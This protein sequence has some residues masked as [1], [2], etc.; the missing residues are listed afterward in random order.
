MRRLM[1]M[2]GVVLLAAFTLVGVG[3]VSVSA[4]GEE[5]VT[6]TTGKTKSK[7]TNVQKLKMGSSTIECTTAT[8]T[9]EVKST[10][11]TTH[12]EVVTYGGCSG[13]G[14]SLN[15]SPAHFEVYANGSEKLESRV[16]VSSES[17]IC[18]VYIEPQTMTGISYTN[19]SGKVTA[20][21]SVTGIHY[22][23]T[24]EECGGAEG[25]NGSY[26]GSVQ[27]ELEGGTVEWKS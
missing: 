8:G 18:K 14:V 1:M 22:K 24:G 27:A 5:F 25:T 11:M 10:T 19:S 15:V 21:T 13:L 26:S 23:P 12:K 20:T 7:Q 6:S 17:L 9:G 4:S 3:A 2:F 16:T